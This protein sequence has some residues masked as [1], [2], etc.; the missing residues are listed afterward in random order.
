M[1]VACSLFCPLLSRQSLPNPACQFHLCGR[2]CR[3]HAVENSTPCVMMSNL[4]CQV[5]DFTGGRYSGLRQ[6]GGDT[7]RRA[8]RNCLQKLLILPKP[9]RGRKNSSL[10]SDHDASLVAIALARLSLHY[11]TKT[12][13]YCTNIV[14][15]PQLL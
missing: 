13:I 2:A 14:C 7:S 8:W 12:M 6:V 15:C 4:F 3:M 11:R 5:R 1:T 10:S 9:L